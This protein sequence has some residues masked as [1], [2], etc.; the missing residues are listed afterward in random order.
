MM[1]YR[2]SLIR[3]SKEKKSYERKISRSNNYSKIIK[4][5]PLKPIVYLVLYTLVICLITVIIIVNA[6]DGSESSYKDSPSFP[7]EPPAPPNENISSDKYDESTLIE[8]FDVFV[9]FG[10]PTSLYITSDIIL[11]SNIISKEDKEEL[12][13]YLKYYANASS[14]YLKIH[15]GIKDGKDIINIKHLAYPYGDFTFE[16]NLDY[17]L[18][19]IITDFEDMCHQELT[20]EFLMSSEWDDVLERNNGGIQLYFKHVDGV[21]IPFYVLEICNEGYT[22]NK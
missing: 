4:V 15:L 22:L 18:S 14:M 16:C 21:Y 10:S 9:A 2:K 7:V 11:D 5:L 13:K 17:E 6:K 3:V 1:S 20:Q 8:M 12:K 19:S